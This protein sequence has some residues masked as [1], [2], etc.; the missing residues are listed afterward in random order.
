MIINTNTMANNTYTQLTK[1]TGAVAKSMEKLSS[2]L[3]INKAG[4]DAAGLAISE[5]MRSQIR[6]LDQASRNAQDGISLIQTAEG[7]LAVGQDMLQRINELAV[8]AS[9][10]TYDAKDLESIHVEIDALLT[11]LDKTA[12]GMEFNGRKLL[13]GT[14][15]IK[16]AV[17]AN[18]EAVDVTI[19][20]M[21]TADLGDATNKLASFKTGGANELVD[22]DTA[23]LLV[24]ASKEAINSL[25]SERSKLGAK[26]NAMEF[27][28]Q[29]LNTSSEN[30]QA[31]ESR[32]R[33]VDVAKEMMQ[34]TKNQ[35][36]QQ[37][38]SAMLMQANQ[39][40]QQ[41]LQLLR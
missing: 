21:G 36:L 30:L 40:P 27:T 38:A 6:G 37:A 8:Q 2:G 15:D 13:D 14:A 10:E 39:A 7:G 31:A 34:L 32:I 18:G 23:Q 17:G 16:V 25:S 1:N 5:K 4:D 22:R 20:S 35:V 26:Q 11:E 28:I 41:A 19:S 29:N 3:R 9:S 12:S 24:S 33:D